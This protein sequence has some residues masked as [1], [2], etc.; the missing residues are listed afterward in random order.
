M[1]VG[2]GWWCCIASS[3]VGLKKPISDKNSAFSLPV[4][5]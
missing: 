5:M 1:E 2:A 3:Y 4:W